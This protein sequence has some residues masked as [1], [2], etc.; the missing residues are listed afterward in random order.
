MMKERQNSGILD[1]PLFTHR[2]VDLQERLWHPLKL[3]R[4]RELR[5]QERTGGVQVTPFNAGHVLGST[6]LYFESSEGKVFYTGDINLSDQALMKKALIPDIPPPDLL[7]VECTRGTTDAGGEDYREIQIR[8]FVKSLEEVLSRGGNVLVP[9]FALG[10]QQETLTLLHQLKTQGKLSDYPIVIGGMGKK[11]S[12]I[13]DLYGGHESRMMN[14]FSLIKD[15][16]PRV[17]PREK[18]PWWQTHTPTIFAI[19]AGMLTEK[20]PAYTAA[21]KFLSKEGNAV[22][23]VGYVDAETPGG[24]LLKAGQGGKVTLGTD[25]PEQDVLCQIK[26]FDFTAH[27]HRGDILSLVKKLKPRKTL[28]V[29]GDQPAL[30]WFSGEIKNLGLDCDIPQPG[31]RYSL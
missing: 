18:V 22:F 4:A 10:K 19:S 23:F 29:H 5:S 2:E 31:H 24:R 9:C 6:C 7:I 11:I 27:A 8:E 17:I 25:S 20:T 15:M 30:E 21:E 28:L 26:R 1:Y 3:G 12:E 13:Y 16:R 14:H